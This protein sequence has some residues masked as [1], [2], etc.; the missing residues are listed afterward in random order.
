MYVF[1]LVFSYKKQG[2]IL[3]LKD[4]IL[5]EKA[6]CLRIFLLR[7]EGMI[8]KEDSYKLSLIFLLAYLKVKITLS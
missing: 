4:L 2:M 5:Q 1:F 6:N 7:L 8:K 3:I